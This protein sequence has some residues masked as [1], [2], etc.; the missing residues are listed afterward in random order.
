M[1]SSSPPPLKETSFDRISLFTPSPSTMPFQSLR[2][3]PLWCAANVSIHLFLSS[4]MFGFSHFC[5]LTGGG[6][7][8]VRYPYIWFP[9]LCRRI[10]FHKSRKEKNAVNCKGPI[11]GKNSKYLKKKKNGYNM[12]VLLHIFYVGMCIYMYMHWVRYFC[13][14]ADEG[15]IKLFRIC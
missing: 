2:R 5:L 11:K 3:F 4:V 6:G 14:R 1:I 12:Y 13:N 8:D 7:L 15:V 10:F 9:F